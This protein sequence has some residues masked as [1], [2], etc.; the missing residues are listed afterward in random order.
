MANF[1]GNSAIF[2]N[3]GKLAFTI[4]Y[5]GLNKS[6]KSENSGNKWE[7]I[8]DVSFYPIRI[9]RVWLS[10][11]FRNNSY[12]I[13][14]SMNWLIVIHCAMYFTTMVY[15]KFSIRYVFEPNLKFKNI[16]WMWL[17]I[18]NDGEPYFT[19]VAFEVINLKRLP[20]YA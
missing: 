9:G 20:L 1:S 10:L 11:V 7:N 14:F 18:W 3:F 8:I 13:E 16:D 5:S 4:D 19:K 15:W 6:N 12:F 17:V 2:R